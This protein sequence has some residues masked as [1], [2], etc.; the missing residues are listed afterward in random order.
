[1]QAEAGEGKRQQDGGGEAVEQPDQPVL[2]QS[3]DGQRQQGE[4]EP[5]R[6]RVQIQSIEQPVEQPGIAGQ[7]QC[8]HELI[9]QIAAGG[10]AVEAKGD[11][12]QHDAHQQ[13]AVGIPGE[14]GE[15]HEQEEQQEQGGNPAHHAQQSGSTSGAGRHGGIPFHQ[16]G[17][18]QSLPGGQIT[19]GASVVVA[20]SGWPPPTGRWR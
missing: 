9:P 8:Q 2:E 6:S 12:H 14:L 5:E 17:P 4:A 19:H 15:R 10:E 11:D 7:R 20:A 18:L 13:G 1:M 16:L 3:G